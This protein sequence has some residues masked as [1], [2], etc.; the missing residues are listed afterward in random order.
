MEKRLRFD[1]EHF[2]AFKSNLK[3]A[4]WGDL[5]LATRQ[6]WKEILEADSE[7]RMERYLGL[8]WYERGVGGAP[9]ED[10]RNGWYERD[11]GTIVGTLRLRIRRTR[12]RSFLPAGVRS[13][14]RRAPELEQLIKEAFLK[15]ISTR[16]VGPVVALITDEPVSAQTV[17]RLTRSLDGMAQQFHRRLLKDEWAY[18]MLDGVYLKVKQNSQVKRTLLLVA[19][20]VRADGSREL[21]D[22]LRAPG[23]S[24]SAWEGFLNNL[25]HRGLRGDQLR[26]IVT[27][28]C[29]GLAAAL[30]TVYPRVL[31][32]RCWV[33]KMRNILDRV[34]KREQ[35]EV[36][37]G[38]QKI[39]TARNRK[40]ARAAFLRFKLRWQGAYPGT[41]KQ[42]ERDLPELLN[43]YCFEKS[44][45]RKLR[46][47]NAIERCFVEVRRRTRPM[48]TFVNMA[49]VDRII[50]A[51]FSAYNQKH[52]KRTLSVFTQAA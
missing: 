6:W 50:F 23:E 12:K 8:K 24:Q 2:K 52:G 4:L 19:Y 44:L 15:G 34:K 33:H 42:L 40:A 11:Y 13:L 39:Y 35:P 27:D 30:Q 28:G 51:I 5:H 7:A 41:V 9:R 3:E 21:I 18:L 32:Q 46:T 1:S 16:Q 29:A 45:W 49:S 25:F 38:A 22:F 43:F 10:S 17:S 37:K 31:H 20:G 14:Q 26:L 47:T 36:K 48:V